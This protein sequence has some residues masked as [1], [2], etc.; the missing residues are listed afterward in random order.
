MSRIG[1]RP[2][3]VP[4]GVKVE[5]DDNN[6][7]TVTV[8]AVIHPM[9]EEHYIEWI[10]LQTKYGNQ[11]RFLK[12][13]EAPEACFLLCSLQKNRIATKNHAPCQYDCHQSASFHN[14]SPPK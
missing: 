11:H 2:I 1:K 4:A 6:L 14:H 5:V 13:G 3:S 9:L 10:S 8:G 12:P 7:V